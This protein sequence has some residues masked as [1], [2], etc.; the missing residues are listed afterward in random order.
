MHCVYKI[1]FLDRIKRNDPPFYYIGSLA[2]YKFENGL[3]YNKRNRIYYGSSAYKG[4]KSIC[5]NDNPKVEILY[6]NNDYKRV[7]YK[8]REFHILND[9]VRNELYFNLSIACDSYNYHEIGCAIYKHKITGKQVKLRVDDELVLNGTY[10]HIVKGVKQNDKNLKARANGYS[11]F[12]ENSVLYNNHCNKKRK[13]MTEFWS[14]DEKREERVIAIKNGYTD[15]VR[16]KIS[17]NIK[18]Y[19]LNMCEEKKIELRNSCIERYKNMDENKK[20]ERANKISASL[21]ISKKFNNYIESQKIKRKGENNP[22]ATRVYW[23]G[24]EFGTLKDFNLYIKANG[25]NKTKSHD[26]VKNNPTEHRYI[27]KRCDLKKD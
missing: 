10:I 15:K 7:L 18:K 25:L 3:L 27:I 6:K 12:K 17:N 20:I 24:L 2:N 11:T 4:Y 9:V 13:N 8:E 22:C 23:D 1:T 5:K 16:D 26:I 19:Y 21:S 14:D